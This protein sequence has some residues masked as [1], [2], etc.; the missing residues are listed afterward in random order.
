LNNVFVERLQLR[1]HVQRAGSE[2]IPP[3]LPMAPIQVL[4]N[5]L[6]YD[7]SQVPIPTDACQAAAVEHR[8]N[9]AVH[10]FHRTH[11]LDFRLYDLLRHA[12]G[13]PLLG[14]GS[15]IVVSDRLVR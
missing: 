12:L 5:N 10:R 6:L 3:F 4:T 11:Q 13:L 7:F 14:P 8:R 1:K 2:R 15:G 9:Q